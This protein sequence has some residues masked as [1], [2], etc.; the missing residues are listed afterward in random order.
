MIKYKHKYK[1]VLYI[2]TKEELTGREIQDLILG[3]KH[4]L[5]LE[6]QLYNYSI[7]KIDLLN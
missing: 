1:L 3:I 2:S 5:P 4:P 6:Q 7:S